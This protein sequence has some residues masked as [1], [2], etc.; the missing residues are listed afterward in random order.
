MTRNRTKNPT[1]PHVNNQPKQ[2]SNYPYR[3]QNITIT[4][5]TNNQP[6]E[7]NKTKKTNL[8]NNSMECEWPNKQTK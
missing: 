7:P 6:F 3:T 2:I 8:K 1:N 4:K 5:T